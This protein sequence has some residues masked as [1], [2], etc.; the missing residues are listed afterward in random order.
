MIR[1]YGV[2]V[3]KHSIDHDEQLFL[4]PLVSGA[5]ATLRRYLNRF[6]FLLGAATAKL[7]SA[8]RNNPTQA[9]KPGFERQLLRD[10][11]F[12]SSS[13]LRISSIASKLAPGPS[14]LVSSRASGPLAG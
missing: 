11:P 2:T 7:S 12:G 4:V 14:E 10:L 13:D 6:V 8:R 1:P 3:S 9:L 5:Q